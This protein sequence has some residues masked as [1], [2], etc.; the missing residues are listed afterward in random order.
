M[1]RSAMASSARVQFIVTLRTEYLG[2]FLNPLL[3][4][5]ADW[6]LIREVLIPELTKEELIEVILQPT[7]TEPLPG[8]SEAPQDR[9]RFQYEQGLAETIAKEARRYGGTNQESVLALVHAVC[10]RLFVLATLRSDRVARA[11]DLKN[12]GGID[13]GLL[14][15]VEH[16]VKFATTGPDRKAL[17]KLLMKLFIRQPD[18]SVTRDLLFEDT[19]RPEW[20]GVTSLPAM[21]ANAAAP[22]VR[23]LDVSWCNLRGQEG[24]YVSL[25]HDALAPVAAQLA[26]DASRRA[27]GRTKMADAL[28]MH[29]SGDFLCGRGCLL[30]RR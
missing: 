14:K 29:D 27:F 5:P 21:A 4:T 28:W 2:R 22:N 16:L 18:G 15:Y 20:T 24:H 17:K 3:Q 9:Y 23:L 8:T 25:G 7:S 10:S 1:L 30:A 11:G 26:E 12:I 13:K 6:Q 19:L